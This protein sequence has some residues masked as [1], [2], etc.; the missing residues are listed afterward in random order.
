MA[1]W[2]SWRRHL[3]TLR[4]KL[5]REIGR[6][7]DQGSLSPGID[8]SRLESQMVHA[9]F[10]DAAARLG[11]RCRFV[12]ADFLSI[13]DDDGP[14]F[15]MAGVYNDLDGFAAGVICG[16]KVLSRRFLA[17]AGSSIPRGASFRWNDERNAVAFA[18]SL[19]A[20]C[21]TK[22]ARNTSSSAGVSVGLRTSEAI[23]KGFRRSA[24]YCDEVLIE[25]HVAGDDYRLLVY[26]GECLSALLRDR[27]HVIGNGRDS[28]AVLIQRENAGRI[29]SESWNLGDPELM[30]LRADAR[31]RKY[32]AG[33]GLSLSSVPEHGRLVRLS[34][35]A[36]YGIGT[37]YRECIRVVHPAIISAAEHAA[38]AA[39]VVLAGIDIIAPDISAPVHAVN[40][41]NT[42]PSTELHYFA[43]NRQ[44]RTDPFTLILQDA[45]QGRRTSAGIRGR[46]GAA[47]PPGTAP[48]R[49]QPTA[50]TPAHAQATAPT[51]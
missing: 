11:L 23:R 45:V 38:R 31:T 33:Q 12:T 51:A 36:N 50:P 7:L 48:D 21:V 29:T 22:P 37:S 18:L 17:D 26:K 30:P 41:I 39:G 9:L 42:T 2:T 32:L 27:P 44:E 15:R 1:S 16:D 43:A 34:R 13:E 28:I 14:V 47:P 40:E 8:T 20:P 46:H 10:A 19:G 25:E 6:R 49:L 24:L 3:G 5:R 35:L 4:H